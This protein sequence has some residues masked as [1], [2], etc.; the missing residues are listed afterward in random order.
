MV[1]SSFDALL[2]PPVGAPSLA[3]SCVLSALRTAIGLAVITV[4]AYEEELA[5]FV[6]PTYP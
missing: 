5:A 3:E 6:M 2:V 1:E 4:R